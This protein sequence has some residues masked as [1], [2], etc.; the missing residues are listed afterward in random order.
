MKSVL[1]GQVLLL[2]IMSDLAFAADGIDPLKLSWPGPGRGE[3]DSLPTG[4]GDIGLN[5]WTDKNGDILLYVGKTDAWGEHGRL[6][7]VGKVRVKVDPPFFTSGAKLTEEIDLETSTIRFS[8]TRDGRHVTLS[9]WVDANNQIIHIETESSGPVK[10]T[11]HLELWGTKER[12]LAGLE[13]GYVGRLSA[14]ENPRVYPDVVVDASKS[15]NL[16]SCLVWYH[17]NKISVYS[18]QLALQGL[19][20]YPRKADPLL[21]RTFGCAVGGDGFKP[22][23]PKTLHSDGAKKHHHIAICPLTRQTNTAKEWLDRLAKDTRA[24]QALDVEKTRKAHEEWWKRFWSR[25]RVIVSGGGAATDNITRGWHAH[26]YLTACT[27]RGSYPIKFNGSIF[28]V[29]G[30]GAKGERLPWVTADFR[31]WGAPFWFQNQRHIYWPMLRAGDYENMLPFFRMYLKALDLA[32]Y[33]T[34]VYYRHEGAFFP[35]TMF[36]WGTHIG[37]NYG[38][39]RTGKELGLADSGYIKRYWQGGL[40]LTAMMLTYYQHTKDREF[41]RSTLLPLAQG[42]VAFYDQHYKRDKKGKIVFYPAQ[43]LESIWDARNPLP[44]I[45]GLRSCLPQLL[46]LPEGLATAKQRT[47]WRRMLKELPGLPMTTIQGKRALNSADWVGTGRHNI[48]N[49]RLYAVWPYGLYGVG[50]DDLDMAIHSY[51]T[52]PVKS[53]SHYCWVNDIVFAAHLGLTREAMDHL[54]SRFVLKGPFRF[55]AMYYH[56]DWIPDHDNGGVCQNTVQSMLLQDVGDK[57]HLLP[58]WP[59]EWNVRFKLHAAKQTAVECEYN[60]GKLVSLKVTPEAR[61]KDVVVPRKPNQG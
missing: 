1:L 56:G 10:Q 35:E 53:N 15:R 9:L 2:V 48:E 39:N 7:K 57:I 58:A 24:L 5:A 11:V 30:Y 8:S 50:R 59:K 3:I 52:R 26:R 20:K 6:L 55:P 29:A 12:E 49:A 17:R 37:T 41:A 61:R 42:I 18:A 16:L 34:K 27:A 22:A 38:W 32:K 21:N 28:N 33:R 46:A 31:S 13:S 43:V 51:H 44:E 25:S 54:A 47:Q 4:N 14:R 40:E 45:A 60:A 19:G 23:D 36:F